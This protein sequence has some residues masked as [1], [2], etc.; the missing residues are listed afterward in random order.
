MKLISFLSPKRKQLPNESTQVH[1]IS[2]DWKQQ[3]SGQSIKQNEFFLLLFVSKSSRILFSSTRK[4]ITEKI[5]SLLFRL[6]NDTLQGFMT[7]SKY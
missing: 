1:L 5:S 6:C 3:S 7:L 2:S 4:T